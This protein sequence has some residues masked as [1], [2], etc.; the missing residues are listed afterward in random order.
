LSELTPWAKTFTDLK[1]RN[2]R[3]SPIII[4]DGDILR[5]RGLL[6]S[7]QRG[8]PRDH[9]HLDE[10]RCELDRAIVL[11]V[12][13]VP[14]GVVTMGSKIQVRDLA[15]ER[16]ESYRLVYPRDA[17]AAA[18]RLSV[19]APLGTALLGNSAGDVVEWRMP[20]GTR[21]FRIERVVQESRPAAAAGLSAAQSSRAARYA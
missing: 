5:L 14:D 10:L 9:A 19:L 11:P 16:V 8:L 15:T 13:E 1:E 2:M 21:C 6:G 4:S 20:G 17:D 3:E 12:H 7:A 18:H